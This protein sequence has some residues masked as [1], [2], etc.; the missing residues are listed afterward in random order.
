M[1]LLFARTDAHT[2]T[3]IFTYVHGCVFMTYTYMF[4]YYDLNVTRGSLDEPHPFFHN[5][6]P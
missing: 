6:V 4:N 2:H 3:L 5:N 1:H